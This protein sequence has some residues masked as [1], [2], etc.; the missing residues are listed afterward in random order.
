ML[1]SIYVENARMCLWVND[2]KR[3]LT[4]CI[5]AVA[6]L[7]FC[8]VTIAAAD[9]IRVGLFFGND[10][11]PTANLA[12]E[13]GSGYRFGFF[14]ANDDFFQVGETPRERITV[15]KDRNI[16]L[17]GGSFYEENP[18]EGTTLIGAY[19]LQLSTVFQ[20]FGEAAD[21]AKNYPYGFPAY[22]DGAYRVRFEFYSTAENAAA[23]AVNYYDSFVVGGS[24][25]CYTVV[26]STTGNILFEFD[27]HD[28]HCLGIMPDLTGASSPETWFKGYL[29]N[30]GFEYNRRLGNDITVVNVVSE[31]DYLCGVLPQEFV[32][33]GGI[34]SLKAAAVAA[35]TFAR[36]QS[37]HR[38]L[39]FDVCTT[40]N[41]Q[42]YRGVYKRD[43]ASQIRR[44]VEETEGV[45]IYYNGSLIQAVYHAASGGKLESAYN[46]WQYGY[47]YLIA[48]EDPYESSISFNSKN[49]SYTVTSDQIRTMLER[50]G[51]HLSAIRSMETTKRTEIGNVDQ[52]VITD[53]L[54]GKVT[55]SH[56]NV[57]VLNGIA[58]VGY[59][60]RNFSIVAN[61]VDEA[62][63][64]SYAPL[65]V[66]TDAGQLQEDTVR[67]LTARGE[68]SVNS[69]DATVLTDSGTK[70]LKDDVIRTVKDGYNPISWTLVG[71]GYGHNV[72]L[73]QWGAY[74]M[75]AQGKSYEEILA[76]YYP[77]TTL[78]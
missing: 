22:I 66:Q 23:D 2:M 37:K 5:S 24:S 16:Y 47:P 43:Y 14:D 54:G 55:F 7:L 48:Q 56:D 12:N 58:G 63:L 31:N 60:S 75:A 32:C 26:D 73:S 35:R 30:G 1:Y 11:L 78:R 41:C 57:R 61:Y 45:K 20:T 38:S 51:Y 52:V 65:T 13:V 50:N 34:E 42:V 39:G 29:Y 9:P 64:I 71:S 17:S 18:G 25:T 74:A 15:C 44:A 33:S 27:Y 72:G 67:V 49:W 36:Q 46:T 76:F 70:S 21:E 40:T 62:Y 19:H 8:V 53:Y 77:G 4:Y 68:G 6:A 3:I 59:F 28:S 10:A 69:T